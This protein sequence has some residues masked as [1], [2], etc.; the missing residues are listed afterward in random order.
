MQPKAKKGK[1]GKGEGDAEGGDGKK[2]RKK[3]DP[4]APKGALSAFM[5][6][7][8]ATREKV[9]SDNP[10]EGGGGQRVMAVGYMGEV[11]G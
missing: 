7:S 1:A 11:R 10:G 5:Y 2:K 6:F 3:K 9:K 4:N 8:N